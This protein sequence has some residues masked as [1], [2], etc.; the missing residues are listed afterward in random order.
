MEGV[1][2]LFIVLLG[3]EMKNLRM[4]DRRHYLR[5]E[6]GWAPNTFEKSIHKEHLR[7]EFY[8]YELK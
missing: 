6:A 7:L 4:Y 5:V 3:A 1:R 2:R 8:A